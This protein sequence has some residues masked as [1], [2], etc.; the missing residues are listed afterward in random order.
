MNNFQAKNIKASSKYLEQKLQD[1][2]K[3]QNNNNVYIIP[4]KKDSG[5]KRFVK[6]MFN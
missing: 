6:S 1:T 4:E 5:L 2:K 3:S